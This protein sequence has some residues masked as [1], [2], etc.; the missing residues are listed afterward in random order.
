MTDTPMTPDR[1]SSR[2]EELM[3][4][5]LHGGAHSEAIAQRVVDLAL[6]EARAE[7]KT[8]ADRLRKAL[9]DAADQVA[10]L[11]DELGKASAHTHFLERNT[12]P[13]LHRQIEH[14]KGGKARWR[15]RAEAAE[16][17]PVEAHVLRNAASSL[18]DD[19]PEAAAVVLEMANKAESA[20][21]TRPWTAGGDQQPKAALRDLRP[22]AAAARRM[23][24]RPGACF[25]CGDVP[26]EWCPDCACCKAG[27][28]GGRTNNPCTHPNAPWNTEATS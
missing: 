16:A 11:D 12:L 17:R 21:A 6:A 10:E 13:D 23:L 19:H 26:D 25:T 14:H 8:E 7:Q 2:R 18:E 20:A 27:C 9:S 3:F 28:D 1:D 24:R 5:L 4:M 15:K 22:G